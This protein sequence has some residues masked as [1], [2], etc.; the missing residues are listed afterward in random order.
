MN[1]VRTV[2]RINCR[3]FNSDPALIEGAF[4]GLNSLSSAYS[5]VRA[6]AGICS[7]RD[8]FVAPATG[9]R[10]FEERVIFTRGDDSE[11]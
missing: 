8:L 11:R 6:D 5:S 9:C 7:R 4:P 2:A 10:D 3:F 1:H